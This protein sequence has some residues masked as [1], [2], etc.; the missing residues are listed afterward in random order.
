[1]FEALT[2]SL[3]N[4]HLLATALSVSSVSAD[5]QEAELMQAG[6]SPSLTSVGFQVLSRKNAKVEDPKAGVLSG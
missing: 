3:L 2:A 5:N 1:M 4:P 6:C